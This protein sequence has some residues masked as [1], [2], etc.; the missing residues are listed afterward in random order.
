LEST[1]RFDLVFISFLFRSINDEQADTLADNTKD[2]MFDV[3]VVA[4]IALLGG[5]STAQ[6]AYSGSI[7]GEKAMESL[8]EAG[9]LVEHKY[10]VWHN[11][12]PSGQN[13]RKEQSVG[14]YF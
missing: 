7:K 1:G 6:L 13:R 9:Q 14:V 12:L 11:F 10:L 5:L 4:D 2:I 3:K 8:E